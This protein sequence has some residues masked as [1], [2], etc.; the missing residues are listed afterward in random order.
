MPKTL[1]IPT[2][3]PSTPTSGS[4]VLLVAA[5]ILGSALVVMNMED[6]YL[7][8][9]NGATVSMPDNYLS[10]SG[11]SLILQAADEDGEPAANEDVTISM[12]RDGKTY[13]LWSG[14]TNDDGIAQPSF[15][16]P[17][18]VGEVNLTIEVGSEKF[19][20]E[21]EVVSS[22]SIII[23]TDKPL[24]QPGQMIHIRT[25]AYQGQPPTATEEDILLEVKDP[26]GNKI[27]KKT[28]EANE[29]GISSYDFALSDQLPLGNYRRPQLRRR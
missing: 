16:V 25:L 12:N 29:Y 13:K 14:S 23:S 15:Q 27:F 10:G 24:Y 2:I 21:V 9:K 4:L 17:E 11:G 26:D 5:M 7:S 20:K 28:L 8:D 1:K 22:Y 19:V 3:K 18:I 6:I